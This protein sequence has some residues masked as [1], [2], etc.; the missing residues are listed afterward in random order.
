MEQNIYK[1]HSK[2]NM[3]MHTLTMHQANAEIDTN[4]LL[5]RSSKPF[6]KTK[7]ESMFKQKAP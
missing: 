2:Q 1:L 7:A 6:L 3:P 4:N 5:Q